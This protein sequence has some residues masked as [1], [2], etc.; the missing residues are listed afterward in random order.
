MEGILR[1]ERAAIPSDPVTALHNTTCQLEAQTVRKLR[2]KTGAP[3]L[4]K[5]RG[6]N[7]ELVLQAD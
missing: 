2:G 5:A 7:A 1:R 6:E 4:H 3:T